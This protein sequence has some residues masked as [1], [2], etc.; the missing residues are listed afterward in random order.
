MAFF[1]PGEGA[2]PKSNEFPLYPSAPRGEGTGVPVPPPKVSDSE[3]GP[4]PSAPNGRSD[5][6][7]H[8][9]AEGNEAQETC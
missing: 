1:R 9:S 4:F 3:L 2:I 7:G 6:T 8:P 5:S